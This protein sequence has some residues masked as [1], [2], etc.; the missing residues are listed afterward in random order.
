VPYRPISQNV[1]H[2]IDFFRL[3]GNKPISL[4]IMTKAVV[5][6]FVRIAKKVSV[7]PLVFGSS[8][9]ITLLPTR[10]TV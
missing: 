5:D 3:H 6:M 4:E 10:L 8:R 7:V 1:I 2:A 9:L